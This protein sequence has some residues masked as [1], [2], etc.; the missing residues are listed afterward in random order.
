MFEVM[1]LEGRIFTVYSVQG[2]NFLI[3]EEYV[4]WRFIPMEECRLVK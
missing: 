3:F 1:D 2:T 4:G